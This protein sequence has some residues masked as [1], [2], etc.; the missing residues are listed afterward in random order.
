MTSTE[1]ELGCVL[2]DIGGR[3]NIPLSVLLKEPLFIHRLYQS[4]QKRNKW[5]S[6]WLKSLNSKMPKNQ[7]ATLS[8]EKKNK[9]EDEDELG[10]IELGLSDKK[11]SKNLRLRG[12]MKPRLNEIFS[13][14]KLELDREGLGNRVPSGVIITG[15]GAQTI[16]VFGICQRVTLLSARI[17]EAA[18]FNQID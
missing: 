16:G 6:Y 9:K 3:N 18:R 7:T 17:R 8:D 12:I 15:G 11:I 10:L 1:K 5:F 4:G 14:V 13:I 2:V